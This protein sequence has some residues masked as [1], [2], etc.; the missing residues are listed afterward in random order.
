MSA[1][2]MLKPSDGSEGADFIVE[3]SAKRSN[4]CP[5]VIA[6]GIGGTMEKQLL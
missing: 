2:A 4:P 3:L 5:I 1:L 6:G